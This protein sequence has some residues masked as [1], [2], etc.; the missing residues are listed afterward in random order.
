MGEVCY[1]LTNGNSNSGGRDGT[2]NGT[3]MLAGLSGTCKDGV[4]Q[5]LNCDGWMLSTSNR[6]TIK[7]REYLIGLSLKLY[8]YLK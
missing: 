5:E 8:I 4:Q 1:F 3:D 2:G 7:E 6:R